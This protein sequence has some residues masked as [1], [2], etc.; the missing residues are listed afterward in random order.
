MQQFHLGALRQHF[1][2]ILP[3]YGQSS[4][5]ANLSS[6][7]LRQT[8][9]QRAAEALSKGD[10]SVILGLSPQTIRKHLG[11][12]DGFLKYAKAQGYRVPIYD[13][14]GLRPKKA[15][16]TSVRNLTEKP[17]P[18]RI[19]H[20]Y[21]MPT[22]SGCR[23][24]VDQKTAG[25]VVF[26]CANYF[27]PM[28]LPY[29]GPRRFEITGLAVKDIVATENGWGIR[30][31][32]NPL[33]RIKNIMSIRTLPLPEE[34]ERLGFIDYVKAIRE[35]KYQALFPELYDPQRPLDAQDS[36]DRFYKD[37]VPLVQ[38]HYQSTDEDLWNRIF[39]AMRHGHADALKQAGVD[40]VIID[41]IAGRL[42][43][44]ETAIRYT[45]PAGFPLLRKK[46]SC[47]PNITRHLNLQPLQ[48]LPWVAEKRPAPW[49]TEQSKD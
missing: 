34:V 23:A 27:I 25:D 37:F 10:R 21:S 8:C 15:K 12:L 14:S 33:R 41:D 7:E 17:A 45:N 18:S 39:H 48:L 22:F 26:H 31:D 16:K 24:A 5:L 38:K 35:L 47:Y 4:Q 28:L 30:I 6:R 29:L 20:M 9:E 44:S 46:L 40:S 36:G 32:T 49:V 43:D 3:H 11:N 2:A 42:G 1:D 19:E 13:L